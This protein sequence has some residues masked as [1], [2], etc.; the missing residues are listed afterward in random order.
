MV[1]GAGGSVWRS[2]DALA[3]DN[4][5]WTNISAYVGGTGTNAVHL[6]RYAKAAHYSVGLA[7]AYTWLL[8]GADGTGR[9]AR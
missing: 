2:G 8:Y 5:T 1:A 6:F 7:Y 9:F 3:W 4:S